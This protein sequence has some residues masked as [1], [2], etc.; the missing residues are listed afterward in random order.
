MKFITGIK[1]FSLTCLLWVAMGACTTDTRQEAN[2]DFEE[3]ATWVEQNAERAETATEEEWNEMQAEY[4]RRATEIETSSA[5]WDDK[6]KGEWEVLKERWSETEG[7]AET[8]FRD[9]AVEVE[10]DS[11]LP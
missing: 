5:D 4:N 9:N 3:F 1:S 7:K 6:T 8:R 11:T 10:P 2:S